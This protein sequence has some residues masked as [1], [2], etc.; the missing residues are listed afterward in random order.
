[1]PQNDFD[2][3]NEPLLGPDTTES[4]IQPSDS[5]RQ[6]EFA[7]GVGLGLGS[8]QS[9]RIKAKQREEK[10]DVEENNF[11]PIVFKGNEWK[12]KGNK[13]GGANGSGEEGGI[14]EYIGDDEKYKGRIALIKQ[15]STLGVMTRKFVH[16]HDKDLEEAFVSSVARYTYRDVPHTLFAEVDFVQMDETKGDEGIYVASIFIKGFICDLYK[17]LYAAFNTLEALERLRND[18]RFKGP[19]TFENRPKMVGT[20]TPN[21]SEAPTPLLSYL[22]A[23]TGFYVP[24]NPVIESG[25]FGEE[26][27]STL[28]QTLVPRLYWEDMDVHA[29]NFGVV[30]VEGAEPIAKF[31]YYVTKEGKQVIPNSPDE[32]KSPDELEK[33]GWVE[34]TIQLYDK[35]QVRV[36][37]FD[38]AGAGKNIDE[39]LHPREGVTRYPPGMGPTNHH[40][41]YP[42]V[43]TVNP[44]YAAELDRHAAL[45][46][47]DGELDPG[48]VRTINQ[49]CEKAKIYSAKALYS[50]AKRNG[51]QDEIKDKNNKDEIIDVIKAHKIKCA[52][53]RAEHAKEF[54]LQIK[55]ETCFSTLGNKW[56]TDPLP[57]SMDDLIRSNPQYFQDRLQGIHEFEFIKDSNKKRKNVLIRLIKERYDLLFQGQIKDTIKVSDSDF[58][59]TSKGDILLLP[60]QENLLQGESKVFL[61]IPSPINV[62]FAEPL[63]ENGDIEIEKA[64]AETQVSE[65]I[66]KK[67]TKAP[68]YNRVSIFKPGEYPKKNEEVILETEN[69]TPKTSTFSKLRRFIGGSTFLGGGIAAGLAIGGIASIPVVGQVILGAAA[70]VGLAVGTKPQLETGLL[71]TGTSMLSIGT[72]LLA[73]A[74]AQAL[75]SMSILNAIPVVGQI[76]AAVVLGGVLLFGLTA[77]AVRGVSAISEWRRKSNQAPKLE[78]KVKKLE[79]EAEK[80]ATAKLSL[81]AERDQLAREV[82]RLKSE[83]QKL[84]RF[85]SQPRL[86]EMARP[87]LDA[88]DS[89]DSALG[90][91][92]GSVTNFMDDFVPEAKRP[93]I[94]SSERRVENVMATTPR[95]KL[96]QMKDRLSQLQKKKVSEQKETGSFRNT[97]MFRS[98]TFNPASGDNGLDSENLLSRSFCAG[99]ESKY[100]TLSR[101][102]TESAG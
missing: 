24:I 26:F 85:S 98:A 82:E 80:E 19:Q 27:L 72:L 87:L 43:V 67:S 81:E 44:L 42:D 21:I 14:Y 51:C 90:E 56:T 28:I 73:E 78:K 25:V 33:E 66:P 48:L 94:K 52:I 23:K 11:A 95:I 70:V 38:F 101:S 88:S 15:D 12:R 100:P 17:Y 77:L 4:K 60:A 29:A 22:Q 93:V 31:V 41:E 50:W 74:G 8:G 10:K 7:D 92:K 86:S 57:Y 96:G 1:M 39:K 40:L 45:I 6:N 102:R 62:K 36:V 69:K 49:F 64:P 32:I 20:R 47:E 53:G 97:G 71:A 37:A 2:Q 91:R 30:P 16:H 79:Q 35:D 99:D 13:S 59:S 89:H 34:E 75:L 55:I 65:I 63:D 46:D 5:A 68:G 54:S 9:R 84:K 76:A 61:E 58:F 18:E 83:N 3:L